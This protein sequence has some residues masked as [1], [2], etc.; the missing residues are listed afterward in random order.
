MEERRIFEASG[1]D[2]LA[3]AGGEYEG[4][5]ARLKGF[6]DRPYRLSLQIDVQDSGIRRFVPVQDRE[7]TRGCADGADDY[8]AYALELASQIIG[9]VVLVLDDENAP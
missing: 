4:D 8:G 3:I 2:V 9:E 5:P 7:R 6:R 1:Q